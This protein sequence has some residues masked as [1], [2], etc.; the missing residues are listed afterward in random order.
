M[1]IFFYARYTQSAGY[2]DRDGLSLLLIMVGALFFYF[3]PN[4]HLKIGRWDI[5]WLLAAL[6]ILA[7]EALLYLEWWWVGAAFL[8][9]ILAAYVVFEFFARL[10]QRTQV[11]LK[12]DEELSTW[13]ALPRN[14]APSLKKIDWRPLAVIIGLS[15]LFLIP[16]PGLAKQ[17]FSLVR[18]TLATF[19]EGEVIAEMGGLSPADIIFGFHLFLIPLMLGLWV[20]A[21]RC[22]HGDI[23]CLSW[24][25]ALFLGSLF[26][27]RIIIYTAPAVC[28]LCGL[29]LAYLWDSTGQALLRLLRRIQAALTA[30]PGVLLIWT[31]IESPAFIR[32]LIRAG[33]VLLL[34][35]LIFLSSYQAYFQGSNLIV[36]A[37]SHWHE[38]LVYL[39][40]NSPQDAVVM[41]QWTYGFYILDIAERRPVVD[42]GLYGWDEKRMQ[43]IGRAYCTNDT[44]EAVQI[45]RQYQADYLIFAKSD[46]QVL[47]II[48]E[49]GLGKG[50]G[51]GTSV[52]PEMENSLYNRS[53]FG[54]FEAEDGLQVFY[55]DLESEVVILALRQE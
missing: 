51:D 35:L 53:L 52:P 45:M 36:A 10:Y 43:D 11:S 29:G 54:E 46:I 39:G 7:I 50:Y 55:R 38:A 33:T 30:V 4:F 31:W 44:S 47:P 48:T 37:S 1:A 27:R 8:L 17:A 23:L 9:T 12:E 2:L 6:L 21:R 42:G 32:R 19:G 25:V 16:N 13:A 49:Y 34:L 41:T 28:L 22:R 14:V 5:G 18:G 40:D 3:A 24:F 15:A 20:T 26:A